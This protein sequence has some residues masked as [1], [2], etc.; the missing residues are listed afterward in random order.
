MGPFT[1]VYIS[2]CDLFYVFEYLLEEMKRRKLLK[3]VHWK[4]RPESLVLA[5]IELEGKAKQER[6]RTEWVDDIRKWGK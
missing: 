5:T 1:T 6:R 3:I 2:F 4:R